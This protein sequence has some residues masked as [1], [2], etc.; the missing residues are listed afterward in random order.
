[1]FSGRTMAHLAKN[2]KHQPVNNNM[3]NQALNPQ[4]TQKNSDLSLDTFS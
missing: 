3:M 1:M 2:W 4:Y